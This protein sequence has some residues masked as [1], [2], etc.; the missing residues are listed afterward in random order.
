[1]QGCGHSSACIGRGTT[2]AQKRVLRQPKVS[3]R[4]CTSCRT[5]SLWRRYL[6]GACRLTARGPNNTKDL[7]T[8]R[9]SIITINNWTSRRSELG[10]VGAPVG[11]RPLRGK[12]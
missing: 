3:E 2:W 9:R 6:H 4:K 1:M 12:R 5:L 8:E 7:G 11:A 10:P